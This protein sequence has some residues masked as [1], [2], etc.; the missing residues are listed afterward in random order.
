MS[1]RV[2][3]Y[4][5]LSIGY[6]TTGLGFVGLFLPLM[7]T[8]CFLIVAVWAFS[9]SSPEL[10]Q[11]ILNHP[12]FGPAINN[13]LTY[14][15]IDRKMKCKISLSIVIGFSLTLLVLSPS[16]TISAFLLSGMLI[17]LHYINSRPEQMIFISTV[18]QTV[19]NA[20]NQNTIS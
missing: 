19:V 10:S 1:D 20:P 16:L 15:S 18:H 2:K 5:F 6:I 13:W 7:P 3:K 9:K 11:M 4:I 17:L 8:T 14:K 12:R